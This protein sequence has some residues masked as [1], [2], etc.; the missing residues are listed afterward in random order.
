MTTAAPTVPSPP[1][2]DDQVSVFGRL[3]AYKYVVAIVYVT[4]LFLAV[5]RRIP[6]DDP[7]IE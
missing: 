5:V 3:V 4:A 7:R 2:G 6:A 1:H